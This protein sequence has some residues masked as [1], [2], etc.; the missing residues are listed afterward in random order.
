[1]HDELREGVILATGHSSSAHFAN[2][3]AADLVIMP[4]CLDWLLKSIDRSKLNIWRWLK[5]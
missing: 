5:Q 2:F 3:A 1:M 4:S